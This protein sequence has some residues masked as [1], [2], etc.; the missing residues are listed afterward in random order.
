VRVRIPGDHTRISNE[1]SERKCGAQ[2]AMLQ[3]QQHALA[4]SIESLKR[5]SQAGSERSIGPH[6]E[7]PS[8]ASSAPDGSANKRTPTNAHAEDPPLARARSHFTSTSSIVLTTQGLM[9]SEEI[10][11]SE[12]AEYSGET[13]APFKSKLSPQP[14]SG[15]EKESALKKS[16]RPGA[17]HRS[18]SLRESGGPSSV[19]PSGTLGFVEGDMAAPRLARNT[20]PES[21]SSIHQAPFDDF[22]ERQV[23]ETATY[24][25]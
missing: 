7:K 21:L 25:R 20:V 3:Q 23:R 5:L 6:L 12:A 10:D 13:L 17:F 1:K 11:Y 14:S 22:Q 9:S 8:A 2:A 4:E 18:R 24:T 19:L 15:R 16:P